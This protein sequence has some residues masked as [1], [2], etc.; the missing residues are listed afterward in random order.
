M[1]KIRKRSPAAALP[2]G[3]STGIALCD[4]GCAIISCI[5]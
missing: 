2:D 4:H 3:F 5:V 1:S